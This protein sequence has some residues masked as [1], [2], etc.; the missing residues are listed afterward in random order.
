MQGRIRRTRRHLGLDS[1]SGS[2][3]R[4]RGTRLDREIQSCRERSRSEG[5]AD[6][7][8]PRSSRSCVAPRGFGREPYRKATSEPQITASEHFPEAFPTAGGRERCLRAR[9]RTD[10]ESAGQKSTRRK[11]RS[12]NSPLASNE[13]G[14]RS[15]PLRLPVRVSP[16]G[17][18][19]MG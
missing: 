19:H 5:A 14:L 2:S 1:R 16:F 7:Q 11:S 10:D 6:G 3:K 4:K 15:I 13:P 18:A 17:C 8:D 9:S 12:A